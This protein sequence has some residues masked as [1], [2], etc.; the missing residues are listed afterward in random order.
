MDQEAQGYQASSAANIPPPFQVAF[1]PTC[2]NREVWGF[3]AEECNPSVEKVSLW[4]TC[5]TGLNQW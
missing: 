1:V 4:L 5:P 3:V 2:K